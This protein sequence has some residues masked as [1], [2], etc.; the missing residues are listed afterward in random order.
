MFRCYLFCEA[1]LI[2]FFYSRSCNSITKNG[3]T[4]CAFVLLATSHAWFLIGQ[5]LLICMKLNFFH[6]SLTFPQSL[7]HLF[8]PDSW[9]KRNGCKIWNGE[10]ALIVL[11]NDPLTSG[12]K[13][14]K[15][16]C[17]Y[18]TY[19]SLMDLL[20]TSN[21]SLPKQRTFYWFKT[22][23]A[24]IKT[25]LVFDCHKLSETFKNSLLKALK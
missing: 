13:K 21:T 19:T 12:R 1:T 17:D 3:D 23:C 10:V 15:L 16:R 18:Y 2:L 20:K 25:T 9:L 14:K 5:W 6:L 7:A 11:Q 24:N 8:Y 22:K 4:V